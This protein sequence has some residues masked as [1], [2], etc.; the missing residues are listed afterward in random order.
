MRR[1][2][3]YLAFL[4]LLF[5]FA[6]GWLMGAAG[7]LDAMQVIASNPGF[8]DRLVVGRGASLWVPVPEGRPWS[9]RLRASE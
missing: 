7:R 8:A 3:P 6:A 5:V 4:C 2:S 9:E 1:L